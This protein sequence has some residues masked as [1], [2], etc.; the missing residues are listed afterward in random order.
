[1][2]IIVQIAGRESTGMDLWLYCA[3]LDRTL[4]LREHVIGLLVHGQLL[5]STM[6]SVSEIV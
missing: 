1:M 5:L 3:S 6:S 4:T 2:Q